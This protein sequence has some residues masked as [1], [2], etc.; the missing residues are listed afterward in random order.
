MK[1]FISQLIVIASVIFIAASCQQAPFL[2]ITTGKTLSFGDSGG[3]QI[4]SF[5]TNQEWSVSSYETWCSVSP[6]S[7]LG[8]GENTQI[9]ITCKPNTSYDERS[10]V[11]TLRAGT[12]SESIRIEQKTNNGIL[13]SPQAFNL[14]NKAQTIQIEVKANVE[15]KVAISEY[16]TDWIS[17]SETKAL[18]SK[19]LSFDIA[20]N[21]N[22]SSREGT[23]TIS[24]VEGSLSETV[25]V[26]QAQ[27]DAIIVSSREYSV[28]NDEQMLPINL[29]SN[30]EFDVTI[31]DDSKHWLSY[32]GT[33]KALEPSTIWIKIQKNETGESREGKIYITSADVEYPVLVK[34]IQYD[35]PHQFYNTV[36]QMLSNE[37]QRNFNLNDDIFAHYFG[38]G[39]GW[40]E[41]WRDNQSWSGVFWKTFYEFRLP[42]FRSIHKALEGNENQKGM[43]AATD[44]MEIIAWLR[45]V[46]R[47]GDAPYFDSEGKYIERGTAYH[48]TPA[49]EIYLDLISRLQKDVQLFDNPGVINFDYF[50]LVYNNDWTKWKKLAN[51]LIMRLSMRLSNTN[52]ESDA[53]SAFVAAAEGAMNNPADYARVVCNTSIWGD[54]Y[55]RTFH[56]WGNTMTS[57]DFMDMMNGNNQGYSTNVVDPRRAFWFTSAPKGSSW[58][59]FPNGNFDVGSYNTVIQQHGGFNSYAALNMESKDGFFHYTKIYFDYNTKQNLSWCLANYSETCFLMAEGALRGWISGSAEDLFKQG[60]KASMNEICEF[61]K[62][63]GGTAT[64]S[65][66]S[67]NSYISSI[68]AFGNTNEEKLRSIITQK[69]IALYPN[70]EEAWSEQRRTGYPDYYSGI[71]TYPTIHSA[72]L[73]SEGNIIQ[74]I[75]Y[76]DSEYENN[77]NNMPA[78]YRGGTRSQQNNLFW[79]NGG[80]DATQSRY[81][82]PKNF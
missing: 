14:D 27:Y 71:L 35:I 33:T 9:T 51:T 80:K 31:D 77:S 15:Y 67:Q 10:C 25:S 55:D 47:Y 66:D 81:S 20:P 79:A 42:E 22:Y 61:I 75:P 7:G 52:L 23:I 60:I 12:I 21:F 59:G 58:D 50:D 37:H 30:V 6:E 3:T 24:Q 56:D 45:I 72:S 8:N 76:P 4:V 49:E 43:L 78:E 40:T 29:E 17:L 53:K 34:I 5:S 54:Y 32:A 16:A 57:L 19:T 69:W 44:V 2:T 38:N 62:Y 41:H 13:V 11:L 70:S 1:R 36:Y 28:T 82:A 74:R 46:D 63:S 64:I 26:T 68:P 48:Y 73:V 39:L 18:D 65:Y